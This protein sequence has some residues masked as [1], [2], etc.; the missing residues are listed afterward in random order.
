MKLADTVVIR[1]VCD[2][3]TAVVHPANGEPHYHVFTVDGED[4]PWY[5]SERGPRVTQFGDNLYA[6]NVE[7]YG[8]AMIP[9]GGESAGR[10]LS[11]KVGGYMGHHLYIGD[12]EFPWDITGD[13]VIIR[14]SSKTI[15]SVELSFFVRNVDSNEFIADAR[16]VDNIDGDTYAQKE[17]CI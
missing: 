1:H 17:G 9:E 5:V 13:G 11:L 10:D 14:S 12:V 16:H 2:C 4:F 8:Y 7:I 6:V 15:P 3:D